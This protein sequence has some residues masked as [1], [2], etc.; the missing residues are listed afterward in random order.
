MRPGPTFSTTPLH[1]EP[2]EVGE[3][4][5]EGLDVAPPEEGPKAGFPKTR[6]GKRPDRHDVDIINISTYN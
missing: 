1:N 5:P 6:R 2:L 4:N 3:R